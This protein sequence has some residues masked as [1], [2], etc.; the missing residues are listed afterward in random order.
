MQSLT[1]IVDIEFTLD[2]NI[3]LIIFILFYYD[4][5][6]FVSNIYFAVCLQYIMN[7]QNFQLMRFFITFPYHY[8]II[9]ANIKIEQRNR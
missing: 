6:I 9:L 4:F 8:T 7:I 2:I 5:G 3:I 1:S